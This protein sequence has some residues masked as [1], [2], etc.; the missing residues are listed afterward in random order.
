MFVMLSCSLQ[1]CG[2]LLG[3][4]NLLTLLCVMFYCVFV[5]FPC[6][7][8]GQVWYL[9]V[10]I[11]DLCHLTFLETQS[12]SVLAVGITDSGKVFQSLLDLYWKETALINICASC[13]SLKCQTTKGFCLSKQCRPS[14]IS[15]P[16]YE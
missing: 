7:V 5:T 8:L 3:R 14:D 2:H 12:S 1:P 16:E 9:I 13:R 4:A 10:S 6:G 11:S 15:G